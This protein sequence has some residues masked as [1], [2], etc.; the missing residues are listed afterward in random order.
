VS[1][2]EIERCKSL[3]EAPVAVGA[4]LHQEEAGTAAQPSRRDGLRTGGRSRHA[5]DSTVH[6]ELFMV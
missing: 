5:G 6:F 2:V 4:E 3:R 1:R